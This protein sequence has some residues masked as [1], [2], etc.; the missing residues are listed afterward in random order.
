MLSMIMAQSGDRNETK[1]MGVP[2]A[3]MW[4][5]VPQRG[6]RQTRAGCSWPSLGCSGQSSGLFGCPGWSSLGTSGIRSPRLGPGFL[7]LQEE[8]DEGEGEEEEEGRQKRRRWKDQ[9]DRA[10]ECEIHGLQVEAV[11]RSWLAVGVVW[12]GVQGRHLLQTY[13]ESYRFNS[14]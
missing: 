6:W 13:L 4:Q 10:M 2:G 7:G 3:T 9:G 5:C 8:E 1:R 14:Q 12:G 11:G